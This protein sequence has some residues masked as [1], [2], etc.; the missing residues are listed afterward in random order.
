MNGTTHKT[1]QQ[2]IPI[3]GEMS[4]LNLSTLEVSMNGNT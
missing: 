3:I 4:L 1:V 2:V